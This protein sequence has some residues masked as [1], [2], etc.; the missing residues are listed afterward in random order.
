MARL[1]S[2]GSNFPTCPRLVH[3]RLARPQCPKNQEETHSKPPFLGFPYVSL[4]EWIGQKMSQLLACLLLNRSSEKMK[5]RE[6][7]E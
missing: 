4:F 7:G 5:A 1:G 2:L 3:V 6:L